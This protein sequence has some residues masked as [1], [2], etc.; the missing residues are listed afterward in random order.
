MSRRNSRV[1]QNAHLATITMCR[2]TNYGCELIC[3]NDLTWIGI[4]N[5]ALNHIDYAFFSAKGTEKERTKME[6]GENVYQIRKFNLSKLLFHIK[7]MI[8]SLFLFFF[9]FHILSALSMKLYLIQ[10]SVHVIW[11]ALYELN[12]SSSYYFPHM[13][14]IRWIKSKVVFDLIEITAY[15]NNRKQKRKEMGRGEKCW[16]G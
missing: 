12:K 7:T 15:E 5:N 3:Y 9:S 14:K 6:S 13:Y 1:V 8:T 16:G 10:H 2:R 4:P 11:A